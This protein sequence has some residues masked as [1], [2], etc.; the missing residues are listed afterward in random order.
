MLKFFLFFAL[1]LV[2]CTPS[3]DTHPYDV[4]FKGEKDINALHIAQ[5][6]QRCV[7][8]DTLRIAV[9]SDTHGWYSDTR[10]IIGDINNR[11]DVDFVIHCGDLTDTG[12]KKEFE[13]VRDILGQLN[14]PYVALIGNHDFLGTGDQAYKRLFGKTDFSFIASRIKFVCL[15]TNA[16]EYDYLAPV[17]NFGFMESEITAD[18]NLFDRTIVIM[19]ARPYSD[20]FN[21]NVAKAFQRYLNLFPG[22]M[23]CIS[24]HDHRIQSDNLYGNGLIFYGIDCAE[25]RNYHIFIITKEGYDYEIVSI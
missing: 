10:D 20:Q 16:T 18:N 2:S 8:K 21:N 15:N 17:P 19:H 23:F 6:E 11:Q 5:I 1:M 24:G 22:I 13:W 7:Q 12:T 4:N 25:H 3:F 9:L 14:K